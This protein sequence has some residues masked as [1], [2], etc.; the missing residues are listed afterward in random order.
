[1]SSFLES[2]V[3]PA[4]PEGHRYSREEQSSFKD[5]DARLERRELARERA[6]KKAKGL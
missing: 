6:R 1:M 2:S 4:T 3:V 5:K